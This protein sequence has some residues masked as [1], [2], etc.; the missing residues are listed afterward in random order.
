MIE[1]K[2]ISKSRDTIYKVAIILIGAVAAYSNAI[3]ELN[4]LQ[5]LVGSVQQFTSAGRE[6]LARVYAATKSPDESPESIG[7]PEI[8]GMDELRPSGLISTGVSIELRELSRDISA[9]PATSGEVEVLANKQARGREPNAVDIKVVEY[10]ELLKLSAINP[11]HDSNKPNTCELGKGGDTTGA[12]TG[13]RLKLL[14]NVPAGIELLRR[15]ANGISASTLSGSLGVNRM[16][17]SPEEATRN[18]A[19]ARTVK[20][21]TLGKPGN[22]NWPRAIEFKLADRA[23]ALDL[24]SIT[25]SE[26]ETAT[27][28]ELRKHVGGELEM[29]AEN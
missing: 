14:V 21:Q 8:S 5:E 28:E 17:R 3:K 29:A 2:P 9:E 25:S 15:T 1:M 19:R 6:G 26:I 23:I 16:N 12:N 18:Y 27:F 11:R 22:A 4:R 24:P 10:P 13:V 7:G 20:G